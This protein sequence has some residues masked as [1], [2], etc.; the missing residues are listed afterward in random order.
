MFHLHV[1]LIPR[2]S[3]DGA[4]ALW[5]PGATTPEQLDVVARQIRAALG[6]D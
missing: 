5:R 6:D 3:D 4:L 2:W 1:H